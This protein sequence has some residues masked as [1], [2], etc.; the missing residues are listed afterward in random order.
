MKQ[1]YLSVLLVALLGFVAPAQAQKIIRVT[2]TIYNTAQKQKVPFTDDIV[3]I[4]SC[5]TV[6]EGQDLQQKLSADNLDFL[7]SFEESSITEAD[8]NG[9]YEILVPDNGALVFKAGMNKPVL[10]L[11]NNRMWIEVG[12]DDGI[13]IDEVVIRGVRT[14]LKPEPKNSRLVGNRFYP[15]NTF[16]IPDH[17]GNDHSR[18]VIQPYVI[19]CD[20]EDTVAFCRPLVYDGSEYHLTQHRYK[21][22]D[23]DRDPLTP[24][25]LSTNF[26]VD[27]MSIEW[28]DTIVVPDPN[29]QYSC[30]ADF[31][32]EDYRRITY[33]KSFQINTCEN[34]RPMRFLQYHLL[35]KDLDLMKYRERA[36]VEKRNTADKVSL[37][38]L[39]NSDRLTDDPKNQEN[40]DG[41]KQRLNEIVEAPGATLKEFHIMGTSSP[42]GSYQHNL[43]L[44]ERRMRA[45]QRAVT[46]QLPKSMLDRVYQNPQAA[47]APWEDVVALLEA[48]KHQEEADKIKEIVAEY[49][50]SMDKQSR[51]IRGMKNYK[52]I[53]TP[54]L[55][56]LRQVEYRVKYDIYREPTDE[57][58]LEGYR[59]HGLK[60][61][62]TR[63]EYWTLFQMLESPK[64]IEALARKAYEES[65]EQNNP[66]ILPAN[67]LAVSYLKRDTCDTKIL[68]PL[69]DRSIYTVNYERRN[70]KTQRKEI[71]NPEE[72]V[73][74]QLCM[75]IKAGDFAQASILAKMLPEREEFDLVKAYAWALGGYYQ[76]GD[77]PEEK[78]RAHKTFNMLVNSTPRNAVVMYLALETPYGNAKA[79]QALEELPQDEALTW[80]LRATALARK[81]DS[82]FSEAMSALLQCFQLNK[83]FIPMAKMDG[84]FS[85][86]LVE[87]TLEMVF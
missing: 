9:Y 52:E 82:G 37:N 39:I 57:E 10:E 31:V 86:E 20:T 46:A 2:G 78:A 74:N 75:Y 22:Y 66:W 70:F 7:L 28:Q 47:V 13:H 60:A 19:N 83:S 77:S 16:V 30:F 1:R 36:Q 76:G 23:L 55:E 61:D 79:L 68:D 80:Y 45:I 15:Y 69:I 59:K 14:E 4:Y 42:E 11:V 33:N 44:A 81:G 24:Y 6:A 25:I 18:L 29:G 62:Y 8:G 49:P 58:V 87:T 56:Q 48:D 50:E 73:V 5:K 35:S 41:I 84:E 43:N 64:E 65:M 34:K 63:Y 17:T 38:F 67:I 72:L 32:I 51:A 12:I 3:K 53:V 21:G 71:V 85:Q 40:L 26:G 54:Y 27:K